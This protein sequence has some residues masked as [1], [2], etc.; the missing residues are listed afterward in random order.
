MSHPHDP[1]TPDTTSDPVH[2]NSDLTRAG[3]DT[4]DSFTDD[5]WFGFPPHT[6]NPAGPHFLR[7][8]LLDA[9][10]DLDWSH[11]LCPCWSCVRVRQLLE[12]LGFTIERWSPGVGMQLTRQQIDG[13]H[14]S[15]LIEILI[16]EVWL[17][18]HAEGSALQSYLEVPI[19]IARLLWDD[20]WGPILNSIEEH[21]DRQRRPKD[22]AL[23][24][25]SAR[26]QFIEELAKVALPDE[27]L[28]SIDLSN[29][30]DIG[31]SLD[32]D[33]SERVLAVHRIDFE[34]WGI[35][36]PKIPSPV[37]PHLRFE[38]G[39]FGITTAGVR[40]GAIAGYDLQQMRRGVYG[41]FD[42]LDDE[43]PNYF[44]ASGRGNEGGSYWGFA[45][46]GGEMFASV[47][48][49]IGSYV[50]EV[51]SRASQIIESY[52]ELLFPHLDQPNKEARV[53]VGFSTFR[54]HAYVAAD[55]VFPIIAMDP[56]RPVPPFWSCVLDLSDVSREDVDE[57]E[58]QVDEARKRAYDRKNLLD[59][60]EF[61]RRAHLA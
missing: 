20:G 48:V 9:L 55:G 12:M 31:R 8:L 30:V 14:D 25:R 26:R 24:I 43:Y 27:L 49:Q 34:K 13:W 32:D 37:T 11:D 54:K 51:S 21:R 22:Q 33:Q 29:P 38:R 39:D 35:A 40:I 52:N 56:R 7:R 47:Q 61:V 10:F 5:E 4:E 23:W 57:V 58:R 18:E 15:M 16:R 3:S 36:C 46:R 2:I 59:A 1:S 50:G 6:P 28:N 17:L 42:Y 19:E 53:A 41:P 45:T 60:I 44:V